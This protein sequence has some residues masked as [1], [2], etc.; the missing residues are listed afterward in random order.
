MD[1]QM[2]IDLFERKDK[3]R[4]RVLFRVFKDIIQSDLTAVYIAEIINKRLD[5][6]GLVTSADIKF[7]RYQFKNRPLK[8]LDNHTAVSP[9]HGIRA[10]KSGQK[11]TEK[12][13]RTWTD[14]DSIDLQENLIVQSKFTKK[15]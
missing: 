6:E 3:K 14:P 2:L 4:K 13:V 10:E 5:R 7:C 1:N 15:P 11:R 9:P 8:K 12:Q